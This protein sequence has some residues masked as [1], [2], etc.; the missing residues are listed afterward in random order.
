[1]GNDAGFAGACAG[2]DEDRALGSLDR[3]ALFG[4]QILEEWMQGERS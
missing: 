3:F 2:E 1:M 4:I